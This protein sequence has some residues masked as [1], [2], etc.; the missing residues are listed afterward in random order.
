MDRVERLAFNAM[1][2]ALTADMWTHVYVQQAN[3]V[4]AGST[5]PSPSPPPYEALD[6]SMRSHHLDSRHTAHKSPAGCSKCGGDGGGGGGAT[7][8]LGDAPSG[9]DLG[10]NFFGVSHFPCCIT[11][12]PQG[13]P[14]FAMHT[15]M[16]GPVGVN[17]F[18][19]AS[20][21]HG[22]LG[23]KKYFTAPPAIG[24]HGCW[25]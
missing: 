5:G 14:K 18:V 17:S 21:V 20:L 8:A 15:I 24:P 11:N 23:L 9:E 1:P 6:R 16:A 19:V 12:F 3:S 10:S 22:A 13:W 4:F 7:G 2:A 25:G